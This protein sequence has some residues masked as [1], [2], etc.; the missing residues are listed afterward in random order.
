VPVLAI[1]G[2]VA[3]VMV[4]N[5][6]LATISEQEAHEIRTKFSSVSGIRRRSFGLSNAV[7]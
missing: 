2:L 3:V 4:P 5:V 7:V 6:A 1:L